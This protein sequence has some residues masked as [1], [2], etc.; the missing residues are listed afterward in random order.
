MAQL[1]NMHD[2]KIFLV[3]YLSIKKH[4]VNIACYC[5]KM[6]SRSYLPDLQYIIGDFFK[7]LKVLFQN[8]VQIHQ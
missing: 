2:K 3:I 6:V 8:F 4:T 1:K 7:Y 5:P